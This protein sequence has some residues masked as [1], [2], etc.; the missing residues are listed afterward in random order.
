MLEPRPVRSDPRLLLVA[1]EARAVRYVALDAWEVRGLGSLPEDRRALALALWRALQ[2]SKA[3]H[4]LLWEATR[5]SWSG[6]ATLSRYAVERGLPFAV[7]ARREGA[8][9]L[10][11]APTLAELTAAYPELR[12]LCTDARGALV[13][14]LR[15][16]FGALVTH[17]LPPRRYAPDLSP[18]RTSRVAP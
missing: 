6:R 5:R 1:V 10:R 17:S 18:R 9:V 7:I 4:V 8:A 11:H 2:R 14:A 15:V 12:H 13:P 16:A 3:S